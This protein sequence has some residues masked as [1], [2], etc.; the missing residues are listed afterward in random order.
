MDAF[1]AK[2][3]NVFS[4]SPAAGLEPLKDLD[5]SVNITWPSNLNLQGTLR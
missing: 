1:V 2:V 4:G 5:V 3:M